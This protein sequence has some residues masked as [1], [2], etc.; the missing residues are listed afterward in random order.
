MRTTTDSKVKKKKKKKNK[1]SR[2]IAVSLRTRSAHDLSCHD[3]PQSLSL[4]LNRFF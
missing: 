3:R 2:V 1:A 4:S